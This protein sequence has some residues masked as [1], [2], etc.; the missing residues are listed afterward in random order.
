MVMRLVKYQ[1]HAPEP[2]IMSRQVIALASGP[3]GS[4]ILRYTG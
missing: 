4:T 1:S 2:A 3:G